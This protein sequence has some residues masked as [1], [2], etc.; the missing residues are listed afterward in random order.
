[1]KKPVIEVEMIMCRDLVCM[2]SPESEE[3]VCADFCVHSDI[4]SCLKEV[5]SVQVLTC[6][7]Y[8]GIF[9][10]YGGVLKFF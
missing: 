8:I 3:G 1:M 5:C 2:L 6:Y 7:D 10:T 4:W 9:S